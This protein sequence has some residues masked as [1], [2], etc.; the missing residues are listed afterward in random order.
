MHTLS[1]IDLEGVTELPRCGRCGRFIFLGPK[2]PSGERYCNHGMCVAMR[3]L[4]DALALTLLAAEEQDY[5]ARSLREC[6]R[7]I[8]DA[9]S[10]DVPVFAPLVSSSDS[11]VMARKSD[12]ISAIKALIKVSGPSAQH[13]HLAAEDKP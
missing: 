8:N 7:A 2:G 3:A 13:V 4:A 10:G 12:I 11:E 1:P 6:C 5:S 9:G